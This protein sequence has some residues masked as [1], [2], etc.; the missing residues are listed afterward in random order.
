MPTFREGCSGH[1]EQRLCLDKALEGWSYLIILF[2]QTFS[3]PARR[4]TFILEV[5]HE[6][7]QGEIKNL[8]REPQPAYDRGFLTSYVAVSDCFDVDCT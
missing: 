6:R 1:K 8:I 2:A 7:I 3:A 4:E 5:Y